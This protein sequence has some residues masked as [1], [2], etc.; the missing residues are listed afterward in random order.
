MKKLTCILILSTTISLLSILPES[1]QADNVNM[2][3][4][5]QRY[6][7]HSLRKNKIKFF[8]RHHQ[9]KILE[10][11]LQNHYGGSIWMNQSFAPHGHFYFKLF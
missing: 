7:K 8:K 11:H 3:K 1:I 2:K 9:H 4:Y 10:L 6:N 5:E